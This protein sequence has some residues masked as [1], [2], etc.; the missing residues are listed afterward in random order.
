MPDP[1]VEKAAPIY[2]AGRRVLEA[3]LDGDGSAFTPDLAV[4]SAAAADDLHRRFVEAPLTGSGRFVDKL[5]RQLAGAPQETTQLAAELLYLYLLPP[6]DIGVAAKRQ[7]LA[8]ALALCPE[9]P[10]VPAELEAALDGGFARAG[11]AYHTQRDR[12][13]AWLVR[14]VQTWKALPA[15]RQRTALADPWAFR[16][17]ADAVPIGSAYSM[18]NALLHLAFPLTFESIVS[19]RHKTAIL[20]GF[21]AN[22]TGDED[23]DLLTWSTGGGTRSSSPSCG[24]GWS[25]A[26]MSTAATWSR[27][28]STRAS[29]RS[30]SRSSG[31]W[32]AV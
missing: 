31:G 26:R 8:E 4:W 6:D 10:S 19:R 1:I 28:G 30:R 21:D 3:G 15:R 17:V 22:L 9:P 2:A 14:F 29:A 5:R 23:R 16:E 25:A 20:D 13:L 11:T 32:S 7:L 12:Q 27:P 18:R 24:A